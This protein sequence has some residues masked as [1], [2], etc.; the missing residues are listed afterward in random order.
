[1]T[2]RRCDCENGKCEIDHV[3]GACP[4]IAAVPVVEGMICEACALFM[5]LEYTR[6]G[7]NMTRVLLDENAFRELVNGKIVERGG[8]QVA[9]SDIGFAV[10]RQHIED[11]AGRMQLPVLL[12]DWP[13]N[14]AIHLEKIEPNKNPGGVWARLCASD[15]VIHEAALNDVSGGAAAGAGFADLA[16]QGAGHDETVWLY[17]YDGDTGECLNTIIVERVS[18]L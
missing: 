11:A 14:D 15:R 18:G 13:A 3:A 1:M 12:S 2:F 17:M 8:V 6:S 7:E 9:L 5:P 4:G 16:R 10:M